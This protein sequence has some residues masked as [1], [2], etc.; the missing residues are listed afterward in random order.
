VQIRT[1]KVIYT[2]TIAFVGT[3]YI[4]KILINAQYG[5]YKIH[6]EGN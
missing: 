2:L 1:V 4:S 6:L 5:M 3:A